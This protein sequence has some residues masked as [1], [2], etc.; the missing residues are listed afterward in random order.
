MRER[1]RLSSAVEDKVTSLRNLQLTAPQTRVHFCASET[2]RNTEISGGSDTS[3]PQHTYISE[4]LQRN[5]F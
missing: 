2:S 1:L 5:H 4:L 3:Q